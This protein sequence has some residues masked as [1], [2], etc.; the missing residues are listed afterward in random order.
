[1]G[2]VLTITDAVGGCVRVLNCGPFTVARGQF[3]ALR[4][5]SGTEIVADG[6]ASFGIVG[7]AL[8]LRAA[9]T[10]GASMRV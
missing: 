4:S 7:S 2:R 3:V 5:V 6:I 8:D 1:M 9:V 10:A